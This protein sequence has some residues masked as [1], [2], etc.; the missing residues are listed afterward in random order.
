MT[1]TRLYFVS[2]KGK[3]GIDDTVLVEASTPA[4]ALRFV[5]ANAFE[6]RIASAKEVASHLSQG[7]KHLDA[8]TEEVKD[9]GATTE[10][11]A[12]AVP[13]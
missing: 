11:P 3:T 9:V 1:A 13:N 2:T 7:G 4:Q 8:T 10:S 5:A 6:T 12:I